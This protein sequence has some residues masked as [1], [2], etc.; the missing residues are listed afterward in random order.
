MGSSRV[1]LE[2][3][4]QTDAPLVTQSRTY[5]LA[6]FDANAGPATRVLRVPHPAIGSHAYWLEHRN[7]INGAAPS[8]D[9]RNSVMLRWGPVSGRE[10]WRLD[11]TP[12]G[13][14]NGLLFIGHTFHDRKAGVCI[15]PV[16]RAG[17]AV[18]PAVAVVV[19]VHPA[20]G[21]RPPG[22]GLSAST[23]D[24]NLGEQVTFSASASDPD[25]DE[26]AYGW[27]LRGIGQ[28]WDNAPVQTISWSVPGEYPVQ[29]RVSDMKGGE[30]RQ[31]LIVRA[32]NPVNVHR[33]AGRVVDERGAPIAGVRV[34]A[35]GGFAF[36]D[37]DGTYTLAG[38][39]PG[40]YNV[41]A[42]DPVAED[43]TMVA[44]GLETVTVSS[45]DISG[46]DFVAR[47]IRTAQSSAPEK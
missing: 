21:N 27:D 17:N 20:V 28:S 12:A 32:G 26:L 1:W 40:T 45:S 9:L 46:I 34:S 29:L 5:R 24:A 3:I 15:T 14:G 25:G 43:S 22:V 31:T 42:R 8:D 11:T 18:H 41:T 23:L 6:S 47:A 30:T 35:G 19:T 13:L 38:L 2:W 37:S 10:T 4:P 33:I 39:A 44:L 16:A 7:G 36:S